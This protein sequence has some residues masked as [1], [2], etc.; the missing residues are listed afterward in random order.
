[1]FNFRT[2]VARLLKFQKFNYMTKVISTSCP[3]VTLLK[4]K[5]PTKVLCSAVELS[6]PYVITRFQGY[7]NSKG[8][9]IEPRYYPQVILMS[10]GYST[11]IQRSN[12][13]PVFIFLKSPKVQLVL[14]YD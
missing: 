11:Q 6:Y 3:K 1:M 12:K 10:Q 2:K 4:S 7:S 8:S 9:N 14:A 5:G 13:S